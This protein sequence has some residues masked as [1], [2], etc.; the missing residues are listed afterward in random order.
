MIYSANLEDKETFSYEQ[1]QNFITTDK[2]S[3]KIKTN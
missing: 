3:K 2:I 1:Q